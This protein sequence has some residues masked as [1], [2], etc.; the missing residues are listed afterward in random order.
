MQIGSVTG[1]DVHSHE[2]LPKYR[3]VYIDLEHI[4]LV[5]NL[6]ARIRYVS[7]TFDRFTV[8]VWGVLPVK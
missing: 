7:F 5:L 3:T 6:Q 2:N 4:R 8:N 1:S